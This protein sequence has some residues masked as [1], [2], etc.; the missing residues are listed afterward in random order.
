[1]A[2]LEKTTFEARKRAVSE[3]ISTKTSVLDFETPDSYQTWAETI[4]LEECRGALMDGLEEERRKPRWFPLVERP[5]KSERPDS[6]LTFG[7]EFFITAQDRE[8]F[9]GAP[10]NSGGSERERDRE[11]LSINDF[12]C[13]KFKAIGVDQQG[14]FCQRIRDTGNL[15]SSIATLDQTLL[16]PKKLLVLWSSVVCATMKREAFHGA[17]LPS[18]LIC[19]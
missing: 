15:H 12:V 13:I 3:N 14:K 8:L 18:F 1:M 7:V 6:L 16:C 4:L 5:W 2:I 17:H 19:Q 11:S 10:K 9:V